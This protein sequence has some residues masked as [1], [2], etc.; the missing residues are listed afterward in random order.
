M[1]VKIFE[2]LQKIKKFHSKSFFEI[3]YLPL[4]NN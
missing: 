3:N 4:I 2:E 1:E